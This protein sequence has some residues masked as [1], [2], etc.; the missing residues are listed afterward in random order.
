MKESIGTFFLGWEWVEVFVDST[1][2]GGHCMPCPDTP[3][4]RAEML[5][6]T[7]YRAWWEVLNIAMH[8]SLEHCFARLECTYRRRNEQV[9]DTQH[10]TFLFDHGRFTEAVGRSAAFLEE[11]L[12]LVRVAWEASE[13][14]RREGGES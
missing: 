14:A 6:G 4:K 10:L 12:P 5:I 8:E 3:G 1:V 9:I 7:D 11:V 13:A 2:M